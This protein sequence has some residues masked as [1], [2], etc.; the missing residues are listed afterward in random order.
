MF[1]QGEIIII[2]PQRGMLNQHRGAVARSRPGRNRPGP[3][4]GLLFGG[5]QAR[6]FN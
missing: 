6:G 4:L 1:R 5:T 2:Q 3:M